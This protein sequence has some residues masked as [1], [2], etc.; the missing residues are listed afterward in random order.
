MKSSHLTG[1]SEL[2][3]LKSDGI[4]EREKDLREREV[5]EQKDN[6][7]LRQFR[8]RIQGAVAVRAAFDHHIMLEFEVS[9]KEVILAGGLGFGFPFSS[10]EVD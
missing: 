8:G 6:K 10:H 5:E 1:A 3:S 7:R 9:S 2:L 4:L